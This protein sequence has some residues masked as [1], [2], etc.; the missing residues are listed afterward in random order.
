RAEVMAS[1]KAVLAPLL[2]R[3]Q[4]LLGDEDLDEAKLQDASEGLLPELHDAIVK[5]PQLQPAAKDLEALL[6]EERKKAAVIWHRLMD[7]GHPVACWSGNHPRHGK[8]E[9][10]YC[11]A[12]KDVEKARVIG[13]EKG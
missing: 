3:L 10:G 7:C 6:R 11:L 4:Q 9:D 12:C 13:E 8:S 2:D 1:V 5:L